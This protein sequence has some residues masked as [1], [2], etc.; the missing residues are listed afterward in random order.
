MT[1]AASGQWR[2]VRGGQ[3]SGPGA[4]QGTGGFPQLTKHSEQMH[5]GY[6]LHDVASPRVMT[7]DGS[8]QIL[9]PNRRT[10]QSYSVSALGT[11]G[12]AV[13]SFS[14][15]GTSQPRS[16]GWREEPPPGTH[17]EID[18]TVPAP[19]LPPP[20]F[21]NCVSGITSSGRRSTTKCPT[22]RS[23]KR[24]TVTPM[25]L[26]HVMSLSATSAG[27]PR[28]QIVSDSAYHLLIVGLTSN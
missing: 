28:A 25:Y 1:C 23:L 10:A 14:L 12:N 16:P 26:V 17:P 21:S 2:P 13:A 24:L 27:S 22:P 18:V 6:S 20:T 7:C 5:S 4:G 11:C 19:T 9:I 15:C 8:R 3:T